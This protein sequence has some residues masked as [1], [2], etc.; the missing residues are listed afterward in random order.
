MTTQVF[1]AWNDE[2]YTVDITPKQSITVTRTGHEP[3]HFEIGD[4]AEY[5]SYN[6]SYTGTIVAITDK[7]V[8]IKP[9]FNERNR[10]LKIRDFAW[11]NYKFDAAETAAKNFEISHY[12]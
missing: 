5:D 10:R 6:L 12:I 4:V 11:R 8:T 3:N 2:T 1:P 9:R 7:T